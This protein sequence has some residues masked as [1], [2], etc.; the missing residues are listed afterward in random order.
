MPHLPQQPQ[1]GSP[2]PHMVVCGD[3]ALAHRLAAELRDVYRE[4]VTLVVPSAREPLRHRVPPP[5]RGLGRATAL[6]G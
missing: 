5:A 3:D 4:R 2:T 1:L 6:L